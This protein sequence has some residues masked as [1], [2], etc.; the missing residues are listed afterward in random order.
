VLAFDAYGEGDISVAL[1]HGVGGGRRIWA[2]GISGTASALA[3]AGYRVLAFDLPG[4]GDS[5]LPPQLSTAAM[6]QAVIDSLRGLHARPAV[7]LGH[8]MGGMVAQEIAAADP[9]AAGALVL[10]CTSAAFGK[11]EGAWQQSFLAERLAP[12]QA[13]L[14]MAALAQRLVA[15]MVA[16]QAD[17]GAIQRGASVMAQVPEPTYRA[18]LQ[19]IVG[20][21]RRE[22]LGAIRVP[23]LCLAAE[24]DKTAPPEVMQRMAQRIAGA[25][26]A[27]V[28][29]AGHLA[30]VEQAQG[31]ADAVIGFLDSIF[32]E[33]KR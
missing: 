17:A 13:G 18:A 11:P 12:L 19:G 26:F 22:A 24:F 2:D 23:T 33:R 25:Q 7:L 20:F 9:Q 8:S 16:P 27:V 28:E 4:Y 15:G 29:G 31:F 21:D 30:N 1:L 3:A 6:A 5:P 10:A 32:E 14:G